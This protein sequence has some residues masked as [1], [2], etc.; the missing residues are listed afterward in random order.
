MKRKVI[1]DEQSIVVI[2]S[3]GQPIEANVAK[4]KLEAEG[5]DAVL[6][7]ENIAATYSNLL[8]R[9]KLLVRKS[10]AE[11]AC[12]I[13]GMQNKDISKAEIRCPECDSDDYSVFSLSNIMW[14]LTGLMTL[15]LGRRTRYKCNACG[16]SW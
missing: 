16:N 8:G 13:L 6:H 4:L 9:V 11:K 12:E 15:G 1:V 5:I 2:A 10:Q 3:Y 14:V 7:G